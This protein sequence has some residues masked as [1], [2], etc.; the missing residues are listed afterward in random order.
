[1]ASHNALELTRLGGCSR[2]LVLMGVSW[3]L[4]VQQREVLADGDAVLVTQEVAPDGDGDG[5]SREGE[6]GLDPLCRHLDVLHLRT[7][8]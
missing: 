8:S 4:E 7:W 1:M 2:D 5:F 3:E 6:E